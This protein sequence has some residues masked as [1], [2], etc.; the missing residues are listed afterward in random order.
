MKQ[1]NT[2]NMYFKHLL[3]FFFFGILVSLTMYVSPGMPGAY[4]SARLGIVCLSSGSCEDD[5]WETFFRLRDI[6]FSL[7]HP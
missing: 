3:C 6:V 4:D 2:M 1:N 7:S 5:S